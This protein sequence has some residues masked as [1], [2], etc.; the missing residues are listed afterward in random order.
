MTFFPDLKLNHTE[1]AQKKYFWTIAFFKII[2]C[3]MNN[4][5]QIHFFF[6]INII[7]L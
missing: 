1:N 4:K 5:L 2:I 6:L 3:V 7:I